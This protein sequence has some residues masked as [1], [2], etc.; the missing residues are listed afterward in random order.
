MR[1]L[2]SSLRER[3]GAAVAAVLVA[4]CFCMCGLV[5]IFY[6]T[7]RQAL[8]ARRISNIPQ[9]GA[10]DVITTPAGDDILITGRLN[11]NPTI[12]G[13]FVAYRLEEWQVRESSS[14]DPDVEPTGSWNSVETHVPDL[15]LDVNG[16]AL[17]VLSD[18]NVS[19]SGSL[20]EEVRLSSASLGAENF[21]NEWIPDGSER[22]RG[23]HNSDLVTVLGTKS[24]T[25]DIVPDKL[26]LGD[27]VAFEESERDAASGFLIGG[28]CMLILSPI[29]LVAGVI[30]SIFGRRNNRGFNFGSG[31]RRF[32]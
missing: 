14:D 26:F 15:T 18:A 29:T 8:E 3:I 6:M 27:R 31:R 28:I 1:L 12:D 25:G 9:M 20:H 19:L 4:M 30:G 11:D 23:F 17:T 7:P 22:F 21:D 32:L 2:F 5:F 16:Q 13:N 24:S 10:D